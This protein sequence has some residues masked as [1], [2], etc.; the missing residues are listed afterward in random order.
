MVLLIASAV[1]LVVFVIMG[2]DVT[3]L[4]SGGG[5]IVIALIGFLLVFL[6]MGVTV[7]TVLASVGLLLDLLF[8]DKPL[9]LIAGQLAWSTTASFIL[10][11]V[12]LF[13]LMGELLLRSGLTD[14][15]YHALAVWLNFLP[16]GLL[17]TNIVSCAVFAAACGSTTA[18]AA[19]VGTVAMPAFANRR[20]SERYVLGSLAAG[21]TLGI[22]IPPSMK[23][24]IYALLTDNSVGRLFLAGVV[25]GLLLTG[26]FMLV[27]WLSALVRPGIAPREPPLPWGERVRRLAWVLPIAGLI[28]VIMGSIYGG[29]ATPT[30]AA[31]VGVTGALVLCAGFGRLNLRMLRESAEGTARVTAMVVFIL[32]CAEVF[33]FVI[34]ALGLADA[35]AERVTTLEL[36]PLA[37]LGLIVL[38]YIIAGTFLDD[39]ALTFTTIPVVYPLV[40]KMGQ[41]HPGLLIFDGVAFGILFVVLMEMAIISPPD[42]INLYVIQAIRGRGPI[43]DVFMGVLPFFVCMLALA[44]LLIGFPQLALWLPS[45]ALAP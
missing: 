1:L 6:F 33:N 9:Y 14:R 36:A 22:L 3:A 7:A 28:V 2:G 4:L 40:Q 20:Y 39:V 27:I 10:V 26:L 18:T 12:P 37:V 35:L 25:P 31:A 24:I 42:G 17:H 16:G 13:I 21:G 19:T 11:A 44:G 8:H 34:G 38:F 29:F 41:E 5:P 15:L 43:S 30:E 23:M 32:V 45:R